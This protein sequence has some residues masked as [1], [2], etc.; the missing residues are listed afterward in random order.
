MS[1]AHAC[2]CRAHV[3]EVLHRLMVHQ[4]ADCATRHTCSTSWLAAHHGQGSW[5]QD[6]DCSSLQAA[7]NCMVPAGAFPHGLALW[8]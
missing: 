4:L 3:R 8:E 6:F 1:C 7:A 2:L 5:E